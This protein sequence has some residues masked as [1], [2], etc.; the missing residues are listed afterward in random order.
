MRIKNPYSEGTP[1]YEVFMQGVAAERLRLRQI[2]E[3]YHENF[4]TGPIEES[5]TTMQIVHMY[6]FVVEKRAP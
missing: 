5:N 3:K 1:E 2:L 4:G 6:N